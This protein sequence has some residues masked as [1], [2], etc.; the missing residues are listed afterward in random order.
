MTYEELD[1]TR[2]YVQT[3]TTL[4]SYYPLDIAKWRIGIRTIGLNLTDITV[5]RLAEY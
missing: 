1:T 4:S 5:I 2:V 3:A